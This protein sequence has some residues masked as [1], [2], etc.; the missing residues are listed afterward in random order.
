MRRNTHHARHGRL[1]RSVVPQRVNG[2]THDERDC[3][4]DDNC[5]AP[6]MRSAGRRRH[7]LRR[8]DRLPARQI[9]AEHAQRIVETL[10]RLLAEALV[11]ERQA[12]RQGFVD[13]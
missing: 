6:V 2:D 8:R 10:Q 11:V 4:R 5:Q 7:R 13:G 12:P 9:N 1:W 3:K